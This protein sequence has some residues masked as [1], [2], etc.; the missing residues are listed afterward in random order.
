MCLLNG[1]WLRAFFEN[2]IEPTCTPGTD[3]SGRKIYH[4]YHIYVKQYAEYERKY[5]GIC[6]KICSNMQGNM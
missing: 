3:L 4:I 6:Q 5:A 2:S 1:F